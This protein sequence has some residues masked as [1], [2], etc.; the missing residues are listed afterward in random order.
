MVS[1]FLSFARDRGV[2]NLGQGQPFQATRGG[3][4]RGDRNARAT[5]IE[6]GVPADRAS[7]EALR[8]PELRARSEKDACARVDLAAVPSRRG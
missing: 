5:S 8:A 6:P 4:R 1:D 3:R 2:S 7:R